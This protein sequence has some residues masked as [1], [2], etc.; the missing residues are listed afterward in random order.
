MMLTPSLKSLSNEAFLSLLHAIRQSD[1]QA[2]T[3]VGMVD[4]DR[5]DVFGR[6]ALHYASIAGWNPSDGFRDYIMGD[7]FSI[8]R[9]LIERG[10][11]LFIKDSQGWTALHHAAA[12]GNFVALGFLLYTEKNLLNIPALNGETPLYLAVQKNQIS[13]VK[14][15]LVIGADLSIKPM[16]G[17]NVLMSAIHNGHEEKALLLVKIGKIDLE[18][19]WR[20]RKTALHFTM[21]MQ[22]EKLLEELLHCGVDRNRIYNG[23]TPLS[24]ARAQNWQK[25]IDLLNA[26]KTEKQNSWCSVIFLALHS[27]YHTLDNLR[28]CK[29]LICF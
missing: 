5:L 12:V 14:M 18:Y 15:L 21:E 25:G 23:Q 22:M 17:W 29:K 4:W 24:L 19:A 20:G 1:K 3:N 6:S 2:F 16:H 26:E 28:L 10:V 13:C 11:D 27:L 7:S 8:L 9:T